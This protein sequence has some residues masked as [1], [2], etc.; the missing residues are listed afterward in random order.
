MHNDPFAYRL[1]TVATHQLPNKAPEFDH[2]W[3]VID[4]ELE[5]RDLTKIPF[6]TID[7]VNTQDMDD[8]LYH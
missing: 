7:G 2:P 5:R 4:P 8:A 1:I 6:F 3:Q